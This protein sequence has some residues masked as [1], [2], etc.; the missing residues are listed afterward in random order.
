MNPRATMTTTESPARMKNL[1]SSDFSFLTLA[2]SFCL[3]DLGCL[4]I[5]S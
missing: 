3:Q 5:V 4:G 2:T 1:F